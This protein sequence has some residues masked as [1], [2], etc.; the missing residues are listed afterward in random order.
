MF[1]KPQLFDFCLINYCKTNGGRW[2]SLNRFRIHP[3]F[4]IFI[5]LA[6]FGFGYK[7]FVEPSQ[8]IGQ[9]IVWSIVIGVIFLIYQLVMKNK[10]NNEYSAFV[11]AAKKSKKR[12]KNKSTHL[13]SNRLNGVKKINGKTTKSAISK[14]RRDHTHL[15]VIEGKK[16]KRKNRALF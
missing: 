11:K 4:Y 1:R 5:G 14:K 13:S 16:N 9:L 12:Y 10:V 2:T 6:L 15:T 7:L 3:L 8:L